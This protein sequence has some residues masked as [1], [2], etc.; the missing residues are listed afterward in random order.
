M[1]PSDAM[2]PPLPPNAEK[3]MQVWGTNIRHDRSAKISDGIAA[4]A[5]K[6]GVEYT[7][8]TNTMSSIVG[9]SLEDVDPETLLNSMCGFGNEGGDGLMMF[10]DA[11]DVGR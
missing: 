1:F 5:E 9:G 3:Q 8:T 2:A 7:D 11:P 10:Q 4:L 6:I